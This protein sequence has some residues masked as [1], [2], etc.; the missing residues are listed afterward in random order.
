MAVSAGRVIGGKNGL[1]PFA[2]HSVT[3]D[4][5]KEAENPNPI[6]EVQQAQTMRKEDELNG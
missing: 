3:L 4:P 1:T 6:I 5:K 2:S